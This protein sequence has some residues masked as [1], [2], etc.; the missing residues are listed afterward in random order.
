M[1]NPQEEVN[2][3]KQKQEA[4]MALNSSQKAMRESMKENTRNG[5][6]NG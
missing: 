3:L 4:M 6:R 2:I 5:K 1:N